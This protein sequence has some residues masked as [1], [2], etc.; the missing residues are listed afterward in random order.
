MEVIHTLKKE[1][2]KQGRESFFEA[3]IPVWGCRW[4]E[5][6]PRGQDTRWT[7]AGQDAFHRKLSHTHAHSDGDNADMPVDFTSLSLGCGRNIL[8]IFRE[9]KGGR[10]RG[11]ETSMC[12]CF[13][14][15]SYWAP[16]PQ[17]RHGPWLGIELVTFQ[18]SGQHATHWNTPARAPVAF[19]WRKKGHLWTGGRSLPQPPTPDV[20]QPSVPF[21]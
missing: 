1:K 10:K 9:G 14:C 5:V 20:W 3:L 11:R 4:G 15:A 13:L 19:Q 7:C 12:G 17:P 18:S 6:A 8:F 16:G 2:W 21:L